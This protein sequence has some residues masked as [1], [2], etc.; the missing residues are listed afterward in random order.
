MSYSRIWIGVL[1]LLL[2][3][4]NVVWASLMLQKEAPAPDGSYGCTETE[5]YLEILQSTVF[6]IAAAVNVS[7]DPGASKND[8]IAAAQEDTLLAN[9]TCVVPSDTPV[10]GRF[11]LRFSNGKL[12]AVSTTLCLP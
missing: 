2:V 3:A 11:G 4:S 6:P 1:L 8:I 9:Q 12:V 7:T 5:Q 10:A